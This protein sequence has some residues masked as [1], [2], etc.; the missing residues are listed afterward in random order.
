MNQEPA[1]E[2]WI[3]TMTA[4]KR[5]R[6]S[7]ATLYRLA[8][9]EPIQVETRVIMKGKLRPKLL[10]RL[11]DLVLWNANRSPGRRY[12]EQPTET[13]GQAGLVVA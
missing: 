6:V 1:D 8:Y 12:S 4:C 3:D 9:D 10:Y 2:E 5:F 13:P 11:S 7:P